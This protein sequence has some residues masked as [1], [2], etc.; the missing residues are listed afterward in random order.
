MTSNLRRWTSMSRVDLGAMLNQRMF[1]G[2][3]LGSTYS[4]PGTRNNQF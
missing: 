4:I 1:Y 2:Q 3:S